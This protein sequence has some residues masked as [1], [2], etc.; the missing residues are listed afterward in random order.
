MGFGFRFCDFGFC[1][2]LVFKV[3]L[4]VVCRVCGLVVDLWVGG[5]LLFCGVDTHVL[6]L[7]LF[8]CGCFVFLSL[9]V[10]FDYWCD[11][12]FVGFLVDV[13]LGAL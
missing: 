6:I 12:W 11:L 3:G 4:F 8:V 13:A 7:V 5:K 9:F 10:T 2:A 1:V